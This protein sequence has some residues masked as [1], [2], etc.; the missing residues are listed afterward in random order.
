[1]NFI[2]PSVKMLVFD[3]HVETLAT[4]SDPRVWTSLVAHW[5]RMSVIAGDTEW[6]SGLGRFHIPWRN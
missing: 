3:T 2:V 4:E 6:I 5:I 1:M